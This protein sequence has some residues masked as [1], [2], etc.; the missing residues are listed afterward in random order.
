[1]LRFGG[2]IVVL[3]FSMVLALLVCPAVFAAVQDQGK[4]EFPIPLQVLQQ[5]PGV[6]E[7]SSDFKIL[8]TVEG[9]Q[10]M[11]QASGQPKL[12]L[13]AG[14]ET[15]YFFKAIEAEIEFFKDA[16]GRV[17]RLV[18]RQN[19]QEMTAMRAADLPEIAVPPEI[20]SRYVGV[21]ELQPKFNMMI[22]VEGGQ[23]M[24]Q[25]SGQIKT[26]VSASSETK[27]FSKFVDA[28]IEFVKDDKGVVT[29]LVLKQNGQTVKAPRIS[30]SVLERKEIAIS[31]KILAQYVG[32]YE[33]QPGLE[34]AI[35][36]DGDSLMASANQGGKTQLFAESET[37]FFLKV[38]D[39]D[40]EFIKD[41]GGVVTHLVMHQG[42][43]E[44]KAPKKK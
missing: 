8:I 1:M 17:N 28:E 15:K 25:A 9:S 26:P 6:Y 16:K 10:L 42:P 3:T 7:L 20:L 40:F 38:V 41:A 34:M 43:T 36:L 13:Y 4:K 39:A 5:Y 32:T 19:N 44:I 23:L 12:P 22:T 33:L 29:H 30:S 2:R 27:F 24:T 37:K 14:S 35:T 21:Y 31:P 18:L 11:A